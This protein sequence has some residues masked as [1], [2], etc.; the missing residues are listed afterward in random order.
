MDGCPPLCVENYVL[1]PGNAYSL[2]TFHRRVGWKLKV[3]QNVGTDSVGFLSGGFVDV[4][5]G[6]WGGCFYSSGGC[7]FGQHV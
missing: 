2:Q 3:V 1:V 5:I 7:S 4:V 6:F